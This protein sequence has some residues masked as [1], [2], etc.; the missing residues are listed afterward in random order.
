MSGGGFHEE[1][2]SAGYFLKEFFGLLGDHFEADFFALF[3]VGT[4]VADDI[5]DAEGRTASE[6][7]GEGFTGHLGF[8]GFG[9]AKVDEV[10]VVA[11]EGLGIDAAFFDGGLKFFGGV[12][13]EGFGLP[14]L[15][16]GSEDLDG[17]ASDGFAA[18]DGIGKSFSGGHVSAD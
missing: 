9:R 2:D 10:A 15:G 17:G 13:G 6:F 8:T 7:T 11:D 14:L 18:S 4:H 5:G 3:H 16:G 1:G 12:I